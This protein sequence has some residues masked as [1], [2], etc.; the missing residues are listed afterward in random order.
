[1]SGA[2]PKLT[3]LLNDK[4]EIIFSVSGYADTRPIAENSTEA[5]RRDNRRIDMRF[6]MAPPTEEDM[7]IVKFVRKELA[8]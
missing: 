3:T 4:G 8:K 2:N 5:G 1:M 7:S 6:S